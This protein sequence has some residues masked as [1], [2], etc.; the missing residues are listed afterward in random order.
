MKKILI[1]RHAKAEPAA[2]GK[3][4]F[5]RPLTDKGREDA[6]AVARN[7]AKLDLV[8][9]LVLASA[10][11]RAAQTADGAVQALPAKAGRAARVGASG[12]K[13]Q[14][15]LRRLARAVDGAHP[16][17]PPQT[18]TLLVVGHNPELDDLV[19]ALANR[20]VH[21]RKA[22]LAVLQF[23]EEWKN[24]GPASAK[25]LRILPPPADPESAAASA[26]ASAS[27]SG[28]AKPHARWTDRQVPSIPPQ[29]RELSWL[30]FNERVLQ[31][32]SARMSRR[33]T[34]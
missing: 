11:P 7:L 31:E 12:R 17:S 21:L 24:L 19:L 25:L 9:D 3:R 29:N 6:R 2:D 20:P 14:V 28:P 32:A 23:K 34:S 4:D 33:W 16:Q 26:P 10:A 15:A 22:A 27:A 8:P 18:E 30:S 5:Q 13:S 1:L